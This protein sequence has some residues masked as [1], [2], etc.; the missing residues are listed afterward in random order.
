MNDTKINFKNKIFL[1]MGLPGVG[2]RTV[3]KIIAKK[4]NVRF[5]DHHDLIDPILKLFGD[6]EKIWWDLTPQMWDKVNAVGDLYLSTIAEVCAKGDSF[7]LTEMMFDKDPYHQIF[8]KKVL[9]AVKKRQA[10]FIPVR[11]ICDEEELIK[12][13][14]SEDRKQYFKSRDAELSRKRS[15]EAQVFYS[16]HPNEITI[17]TTDLSATQTAEKIIRQVEN[18]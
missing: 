12:R 16:N 1:L 15:R 14:L 13:I 2:K 3:A 8:Y 4:T 5:S 9:D 7:L 18:S 10:D 6:D 11:L 17:D